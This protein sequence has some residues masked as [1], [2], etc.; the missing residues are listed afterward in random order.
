MGPRLTAAEARK[1]GDDA[2]AGLNP[3]ASGLGSFNVLTNSVTG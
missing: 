1:R 3:G 2:D